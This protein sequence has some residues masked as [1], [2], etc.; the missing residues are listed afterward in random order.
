MRR[1][2]TTSPL[3]YVSCAVVLVALGTSLLACDSGDSEEV[4][5]TVPAV[6][7]SGQTLSS[8]RE[9]V[10]AAIDSPTDGWI[11]IHEQTASGSFG[12]TL[13]FAP[14]D[15]GHNSDVAVTLDRDALDG[16]TLYAMLHGDGGEIGVFE[17][18]GPDVPI[19]DA[20]GAV[21]V[22]S[23]EVQVTTPDAVQ[24]TTPE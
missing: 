20:T 1:D 7:V 6:L 23:F 10:V 8:P 18:P 3:R 12:A 9:V 14:V 21:V 11:V 13:G 2:G 22:K 16:E 17:F 15:A 19:T 5:A 24:A 4:G